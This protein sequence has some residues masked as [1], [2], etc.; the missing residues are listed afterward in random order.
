MIK[1][2]HPEQVGDRS[3]YPIVATTYRVS[4]HWQAGAMTR[5][6]PWLVELQPSAFVEI[7]RELAD[8]K[9]LSNG[10][11]VKVTSARGEVELYAL[12]TRR[13][14]PMQVHGETVH[15]VGL[16]WHFGYK[17]LAKG[18]SANMLTPHVGDGNTMIPEYK[19]FL[20]DVIPLGPGG[21]A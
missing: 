13:L 9:G 21:V 7:S 20:C 10:D 1:I 11:K 6:L 18:P 15:Q 8:E 3:T 4:E 5:S 14:R 2:W 16:I 19:A 12:V 17:G